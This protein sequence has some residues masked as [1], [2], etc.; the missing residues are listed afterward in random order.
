MKATA[1]CH[2]LNRLPDYK[3]WPDFRNA[4]PPVDTKKVAGFKCW[5]NINGFDPR[6]HDGFDLAAYQRQDGALQMGLPPSTPIHAMFD[7]VV[8]SVKCGGP[9]DYN[10]YVKIIHTYN[11]QKSWEPFLFAIYAHVIPHDLNQNDFVRK[12]QLIGYLMPTD[13]SFFP[14][15]YHL[16]LTTSAGNGSYHPDGLFSGRPHVCDT[17]PV[18][19]LFPLNPPPFA[20]YVHPEITLSDCATVPVM[21][22]IEE[23]RAKGW[24]IFQ[25]SVYFKG[26]G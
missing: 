20:K 3:K 8:E 19:I 18:E 5:L 21:P 25:G 15:H 12:G 11:S 17:D 4:H 23:L 6:F 7:G 1:L 22:S 26:N 14:L 9:Q 13:E 10:G 24:D 2:R 16:H